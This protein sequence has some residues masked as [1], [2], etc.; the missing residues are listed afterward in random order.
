MITTLRVAMVSV[1]LEETELTDV[2]RRLGGTIVT[3]GDASTANAELCFYG[4]DA[5]GRW[6][7]SLDSGE[8]GGLRWIDSFTLQRLSPN[9]KTDSRCRI[10]RQNEGGIELP[11]A[12]RLGLTEREVVRILGKPTMRYHRTLIFYHEHEATS[13]GEPYSVLNLVA[14]A[15]RGGVVW[16][17]EVSKDSET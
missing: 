3:S 6:G 16:A 2:Q 8:M 15:L 13:H 12:L 14:V 17:I 11:I 1:V 5:N 9:A 7:L 4:T 10:M